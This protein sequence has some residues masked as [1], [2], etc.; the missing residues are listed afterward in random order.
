MRMFAREGAHRWHKTNS[1]PPTHST[2]LTPALE[3]VI[4][5]FRICAPELDSRAR[6]CSIRRSCSLRGSEITPA[7]EVLRGVL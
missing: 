1:T 4:A 7:M 3:M 2:K 6:P 5:V